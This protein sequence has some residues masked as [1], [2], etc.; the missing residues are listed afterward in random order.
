MV[1]FLLFIIGLPLLNGE[2]CFPLSNV[3]MLRDTSNSE[4]L[5]P[6]DY[7]VLYEE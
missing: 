7:L 5:H 2:L 3:V 1:A 4:M 6:Q